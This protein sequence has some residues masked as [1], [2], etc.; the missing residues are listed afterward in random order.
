MQLVDKQD[1]A[2]LGLLDL[3]QHGLQ[4]LF[5]FTAVLCA[6]NQCAHIERED[7]FVLQRLGHLVRDDPLRKALDDG[8][9]ADARFA[10]ENGV[11]LRL[12]GQ[13]ADDIPDLVV[14]AD[15]RV[16]FLFPCT[17]DQIRAVFGKRLIRILR[18][19]G[20][21]A[22]AAAHRLQRLQTGLLRDLVRTEQAFQHRVRVF[23]QGQKQMLDG[24]IFVLH[25]LCDVFRA[26][27]RR[28]N[29]T[30]NIILIRLAARAGHAR[31]LRQLRVHRSLKAFKRHAH[32]FQ[33]LRHKAVFLLQ[34][35]GQ[36]MDLLDLLV[37]VFNGQL[38]GGL[39]GLQRFL[40]IVLCVHSSHLF[41]QR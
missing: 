30:R 25:L 21:H 16:H 36:Q 32:L 18:R 33:Q 14:T 31:Q 20:R 40:R 27:Q 7:R 41:F 3:G 38:L 5:K 1:D 12:A 4:T 15:D 2:A 24:D 10:D 26:V 39:N 19:V 6:C 34:K 9:L 28:I 37:L 8:R 17:L 22:L 11:V 29:G 35:R 13:D 23:D